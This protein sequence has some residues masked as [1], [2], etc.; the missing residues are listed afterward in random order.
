MY[1]TIIE[2]V[3][4]YPLREIPDPKGSVLHMQKVTDEEFTKFGELYFSEVT[5]GSIKA[6]KIHRK[7]TQ[8][9][10]VP[11][12]RILLVLFDARKDEQ[13]FSRILEIEL[14]RPDAYVRIRIPTGIYYGF[15]CL[16][17]NTALI[18]NCVDTPHDPE[19]NEKL[20][21]NTDQIPYK[22]K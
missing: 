3:F 19:D 15:K 1:N 11:I 6:W 21:S 20:D 13:S 8:N 9:L 14:G 7:Q 10:A 22:W 17:E 16:S 18:A 5:P 2:G 4:T 12:G